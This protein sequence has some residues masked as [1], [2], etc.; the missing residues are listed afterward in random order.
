MRGRS[1]R[2]ERPA[3]AL[4]LV[5]AVA[6]GAC[7]E[8]P[9]PAAPGGL[10]GTTWVVDRDSVLG[11]DPSAPAGA[12]ATIRFEGGEVGG[13]AFCNHYGGTYR[14]EGD[15]LQIRI[16][17]MTEIACD[18]PLMAMDATFF[19]LLEAVETFEL[20]DGALTLIGPDRRLGFSAEP[21]AELV[22][23]RWS[24]EG[25]VD[26]DAVSSTVPG[27]AAFILLAID[28]TVTGDAS[29]NR[30]SGTYE[31]SGERLTFGA[32]AATEMACTE[33]GV[34]EQ[35][36]AVLDALSRTAGFAIEGPTLT[37]LDAEGR[38]TLVLRASDG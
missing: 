12:R 34:M 11:V 22:G 16:E 18:E 31:R 4:A 21:S 6:L 17:M 32:I 13:S 29:C 15:R 1:V 2:I 5:A 28:G 3:V 37:L 24:V 30:F 35:E 26:G 23:T 10:E 36:A 8:A 20:G 19:D 14:L 33:P 27:T 25:L 9:P 7:A 38:P